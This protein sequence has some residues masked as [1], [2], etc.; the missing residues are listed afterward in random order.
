MP[1]PVRTSNNAAT[2][3]P[4]PLC[5][6]DIEGLSFGEAARLERER[7]STSCPTCGE[8]VYIVCS[9]APPDATPEIGKPRHN[10]RVYASVVNIE[11]RRAARAS[12]R[13][14]AQ[15]VGGGTARAAP[16]ERG[17]GR[18]WLAR[19]RASR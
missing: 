3:L 17:R 8:D 7:E 14:P 15:C 11:P 10:P 13:R 2:S 12:C 19:E 1:E 18:I 4:C 16:G 9:P 6:Q 5:G